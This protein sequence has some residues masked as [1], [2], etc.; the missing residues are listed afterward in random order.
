MLIKWMCKDEVMIVQWTHEDEAKQGSPILGYVGVFRDVFMKHV[1]ASMIKKD[2]PSWGSQD[3]HHLAQVKCI[4]Q[5]HSVGD[6]GLGSIVVLS[7][8]ALEWVTYSY[9]SER[10]L[11]FAYLA[12]SFLVLISLFSMWGFRACGYLHGNP[13]LIKNSFWMENLLCFGVEGF[14]GSSFLDRSNLSSFDLTFHV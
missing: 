10:A 4:R 5:S 1:R 9:H 13:K 6:R 11:T 3:R 12:S 7:R 8:G 14:T 2:V